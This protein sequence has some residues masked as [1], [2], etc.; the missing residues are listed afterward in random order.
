MIDIRRQRRC[1]L[2]RGS[3]SRAVAALALS[4]CNHLTTPVGGPTPRAFRAL[5]V[6]CESSSRLLRVHRSSGEHLSTVVFRGQASARR[7]ALLLPA[8]AARAVPRDQFGALSHCAGV[9]S[10][11]LCADAVA[12]AAAGAA[13]GDSVCAP[14][15]ALRACGVSEG[16]AHGPRFDFH[17]VFHD[18]LSCHPR[19]VVSRFVCRVCPVVSCRVVCRS[20]SLE[21]GTD[22][23]RRAGSARRTA[24]VT[25]RAAT[26]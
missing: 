10:R 15:P 23:Q 25:R 8:A 12:L 20:S 17:S 21:D 4:G 18:E 19:R 11:M 5:F 16:S 24:V 14:Q 2:P 6:S 26:H 13:T 22:R 3:V 7:R 9:P 1:S